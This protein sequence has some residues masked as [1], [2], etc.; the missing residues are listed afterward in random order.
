MIASIQNNLVSHCQNAKVPLKEYEF[1]QKKVPNLQS[2][3]VCFHDNPKT[4]I[5]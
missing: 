2:I 3:L 5:A 1:D 4:Y